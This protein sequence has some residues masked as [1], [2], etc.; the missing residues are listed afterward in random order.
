[1]RKIFVIGLGGT[2]V[3]LIGY[4]AYLSYSKSKESRLMN[5]SRVFITHA[6]RQNARLSLS[7]VLRIDPRNVEAT[8]MMADLVAGDS[9][10]DE[11]QWRMRV[12]ELAPRSAK[13]RIALAMA[14][15][16][17]GN[18]A[19]ATNS[20]AAVAAVDQKTAAYQ[21][22]VGVLAIAERQPLLAETAFETAASLDPSSEVPRLNLAVLRLHSTNQVSVALAREELTALAQGANQS[23]HCQALRELI[24]DAYVHGQVNTAF[25]L[26]RRLLAE[27]NAQFSDRILQLDV[28][29]KTHGPE[30]M[31]A[32]A[33]ARTAA[34]VNPLRIESL[35][36]WEMKS[37][38]A[39]QTL[40]WF[41]S[42]PASTQT[43][44]P[45][46]MLA[47][48]CRV[49]R[50]DW[51]ELEATLRNQDWGALEFVRHALRARAYYG[52]QMLDDKKSEWDLARQTA[53]TG[54]KNSMVLLQLCTQWNWSVE[55]TD[56][57]STILKHH[58]EE[59]WAEPLLI[60]ELASSGRTRAM[61][62]EFQQQYEQDSSNLQAKNNLAMT[63]MLL[64]ATEVRPFDLAL[65]NYQSQPTNIAFASTYAYS[66]CQQKRWA[67]ALNVFAAFDAKTLAEPE[68]AGYYAI[69]LQ[70]N[71]HAKLAKGYLAIALRAPR[72]LPEER[73]L[74]AGTQ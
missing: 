42:L 36:G 6:E 44:L 24:A 45:V 56:L 70:A 53:G 34:G 1:M 71:G 63:A 10:A 43:N 31:K 7:E 60:S 12:T 15:A 25:A 39:A 16:K 59:K 4:A 11:L 13:D 67:D 62:N 23:Y 5:M 54:T 68:V 49:T 27:T 37:V 55:K 69:V 46:A 40:G 73:R 14:A 33:G 72:L 41:E 22:A 52:E 65:Q 38:P 19:L 35:A 28:L 2:L 48:E 57:L 17:A 8:R 58:P 51:P 26:S 21:N 50:R 66:L 9:G 74:F 30:L 47:A 32:L 20:L 18:L 61:M 29:Q 64:N 3:L